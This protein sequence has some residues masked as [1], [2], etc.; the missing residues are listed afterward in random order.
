MEIW[1]VIVAVVVALVALVVALVALRRGT[2]PEPFEGLAR[3][4][5][6]LKGEIAAAFGHTRQSLQSITERVAVIDSARANIEELAKQV[7]G[8]NRVLGDK[9]ARGAFGQ[10]QMEDL[11]RD[12]LPAGSYE[13]QATLSNGKRVDCLVRLPKP[14][15]PIGVDA[16]F[17]LESFKGLRDAA[18]DHGRTLALR[19][20]KADVAKH[21]EDIAGK[22]IV[23]GET[24]DWALMFVPSEAV[25]AEIH[26]RL[27]E[28]VADAHRA[29]VGI[30]SPTT[31]M[32]AL[33]TVRA[34]VLDAKM[35]EEAGEIR[36][37]VQRLKED[38]DRLDKRAEDLESA[39]N[40]LVATLRELR[41]SAGKI[42]SRI[43]RIA[44]ADVAEK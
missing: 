32:A 2:R 27:A 21:V 28:T 23:P 36:A 37:E 17:P 1:M 25:Y 11:V 33:T 5:A 43:G 16:K 20:F 8:L 10:T 14:P 38:A 40:K 26:A 29:R 22:Y 24:A 18:D 13:M 15:G 30:V 9:Q 41:I 31:L 6:A 3:D 12:I 34:I 44:E 4:F 42:A 19:A 35:V 7:V 39:F